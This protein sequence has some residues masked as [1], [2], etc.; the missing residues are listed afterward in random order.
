MTNQF[1]KTEALEK[2]SIVV[3]QVEMRDGKKQNVYGTVK[4]KYTEH[5]R[6]IISKGM[7][8]MKIIDAYSNT[9]VLHEKFPG[10]FVWASVWASFN[11]DERALTKEQIRLTT[12]KPLPPPPPQDLFVEFCRPIY[13]QVQSAVRRFYNSI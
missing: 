5:R 3:G 11:G 8:S 10:E 4:A 7:V 13:A 9:V 2:D 12:Q 1:E 6:E